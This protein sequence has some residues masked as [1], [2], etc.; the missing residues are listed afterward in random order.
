MNRFI[1]L[2]LSEPPMRLVAR[3]ILRNSL[4]LRHAFEWAALFDSLPYPSYAAGLQIASRYAVLSGAKAFT[5]IEFGVA[6]GNGLLALSRYAKEVSRQTGLNIHVVGFD[7]GSGLPPT[8][9]IRD[10]PWWWTQGDYPCDKDRL[11]EQLPKES[12]LIVGNIK[13]TFPQWLRQSEAPPVGFVSVDVDQ[14]TG[15]SAICNALGKA[16]VSR[17]LPF[18]SCYFD[19]IFHFA[20]P[21]W[22]GEFQAI[23]EFNE[24]QS[25]RQFDRDDWF[26]QNRPYGDRLWLKRMYTLS[27]QDHP[28]FK[29]RRKGETAYLN[30][31][32]RP[33]GGL[34]DVLPW[35]SLG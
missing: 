21:R 24:S 29:S 7:S 3:T 25:T 31:G 33:Q 6:G 16:D 5:A 30:L 15:A 17:I 27:S 13:D 19:D 28:L 32:E 4:G 11:R 26:S 8:D 35:P 12:E 22:A 10:A 23:Q 14:Y 18:I 2:F 34:Q 1:R 9:D 20:V